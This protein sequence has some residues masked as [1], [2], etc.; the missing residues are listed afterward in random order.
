MDDSWKDQNDFVL[1]S[2][3]NFAKELHPDHDFDLFFICTTDVDAKSPWRNTMVLGKL[4]GRHW[5]P[6]SGLVGRSKGGS[7]YADRGY[8]DL[9]GISE[10]SS[11]WKLGTVTL[12][13]S[14]P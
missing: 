5:S 6:K 12:S 4:Y 8:R 10:R 7:Y 9:V 3:P 2:S 1:W 13:I 14:T 11:V